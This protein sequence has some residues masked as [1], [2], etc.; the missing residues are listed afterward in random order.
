M[1]H[2]RKCVGCGTLKDRKNLI[3][4]TFDRQQNEV[5]L[6]P[7]SKIFGRSV[8]LCYNKSCIINAMKKNKL[9]KSL[10]APISEELK[11]KLIEYE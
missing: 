10:K 1:E 2:Q 3:K 8:Y 4:I 5:V 6:N 11:G 9:Q 7:D